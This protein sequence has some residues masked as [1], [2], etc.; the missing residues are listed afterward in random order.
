M[1]S[2]IRRSIANRFSPLRRSQPTLSKTARTT[3]SV[4]SLSTRRRRSARFSDFSRSRTPKLRRR[5]LFLSPGSLRPTS[6]RSK[7]RTSQREHAGLRAALP[8]DWSSGVAT[9]TGAKTP[10]RRASYWPTTARIGSRFGKQ[11]THWKRH[12]RR[13]TN[14]CIG[15]RPSQLRGVRTGSRRTCGHNSSTRG[16][17]AANSPARGADSGASNRRRVPRNASVLGE[18]RGG[19]AEP[20]Q[21][22]VSRREHPE[23]CGRSRGGPAAAPLR[24]R[25]LRVP[26]SLRARCGVSGWRSREL[27]E[28]WFRG[29]P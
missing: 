23:G 28:D 1:G 18:L 7:S 16:S 2:G 8:G 17:S 11:P 6:G 22:G 4:R 25:V 15:R 19:S 13:S 3:N 27:P 10:S 20:P 26:A 14:Q 9:S 21:A 5:T 12:A 29:N 24:R